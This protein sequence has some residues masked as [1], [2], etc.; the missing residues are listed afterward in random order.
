MFIDQD[1]KNLALLY[2]CHVHGYP[3]Q[4]LLQVESAPLRYL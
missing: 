2:E 3:V 4:F 1:Y